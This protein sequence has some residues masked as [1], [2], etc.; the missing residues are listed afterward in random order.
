M[1]L[2]LSLPNRL[3]LAFFACSIMLGSW[4]PR[5]A[6][7][8]ASAALEAWQLGQAL[9]GYPVGILVMFTFGTRFV[10]EMSFRRSFQVVVPALGLALIAATLATSTLPLFLALMAAGALQGVL[11]ITGNVEADRMEARLQRQ[12][13]VR[14][15]GFYSLAT[16][17]AGALGTA[18]RAM[19]ISPWLHLTLMLPVAAAL[20][21]FATAG[22]EALPHRDQEAKDGAARIVWPTASILVLFIAGGASLYL[23]N[24]ASDWSVILLRDGYGADAVLATTAVTIWALGQAVG[25]IGYP[26]MTRKIPAARLA[27][28]MACTAGIGLLLVV[29]AHGVWL[30]VIGLMLMG[31]GTS[32]L[33]PMAIAS[34]ARLADRPSA[35]NVASLSQMA[36]LAGIATPLVLGAVVSLGGIRLAF[37]SGLLVLVAS[38]AAMRL[39][40]PF[41][42]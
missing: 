34:A 40:R 10:A 39:K 4:Y 11:A 31:F 7:V 35:A 27:V 3:Y 30:G 24:A 8:Q 21:L 16:V 38:L 32:A 15:H 14:A 25:R 33:F 41:A 29:L 17:G 13:L 6:D 12:V 1:T 9:S 36:F 19:G 23:D 20:T 2:S 26:A 42:A 28:V 18:F 37:A 5:I 22:M